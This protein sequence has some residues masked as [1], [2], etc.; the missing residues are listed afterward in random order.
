MSEELDRTVK[1]QRHA[2][3]G[4]DSRGRTVWTKP[5]EPVELELVSTMM[6]ENL[7]ESADESHKQRMRELADGQEGVL[8]RDTSNNE[9]EIVR[10]D[11][12]EA[13]LQAA[14]RETT[15]K[16]PAGFTLERVDE[17]DSVEELSL[18]TTQVLRKMIGGEPETDSDDLDLS[19]DAGGY[20]PYDHTE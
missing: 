20:N 3:V 7:I 16:V 12:L 4:T 5:V 18:V 9:F 10:D 19:D 2:K 15:G 1:I 11:E 6:L 14:N 13:A 17:S 8:A